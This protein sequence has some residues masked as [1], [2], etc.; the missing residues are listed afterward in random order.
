MLTTLGAWG[1]CFAWAATSLAERRPRLVA[2]TLVVLALLDLPFVIYK[3]AV[4]LF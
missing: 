3:V 1:L 4:G 2:A